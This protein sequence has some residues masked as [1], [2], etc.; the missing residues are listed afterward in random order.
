MASYCCNCCCYWSLYYSWSY[1]SWSNLSNN[2]YCCCYWV[3]CYC[4]CKKRSSGLMESL[5]YM[6][7][8]E[9][10][11]WGRTILSAPDKRKGAL[12][13]EGSILFEFI[14]RPPKVTT[15]SSFYFLK[16]VWLE[17]P[18]ILA[19]SISLE[20]SETEV[21]GCCWNLCFFLWRLRIVLADE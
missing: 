2:C 17:N 1:Y 7:T 14:K 15:S 12:T 5:L 20:I 3:W 11:C 19:V 6:L 10:N 16:R 4:Y 9:V 18:H 13:E 8:L 21:G